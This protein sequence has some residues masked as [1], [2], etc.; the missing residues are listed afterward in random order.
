[1]DKQVWHWHLVLKNYG[2]PETMSQRVIMYHTMVYNFDDVQ[3]GIL[4]QKASVLSGW[5]D[6]KVQFMKVPKEVAEKIAK[7]Q[8]QKATPEKKPNHYIS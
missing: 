4:L 7:E 3:R 1:M 6:D 5:L 2:N 8:A